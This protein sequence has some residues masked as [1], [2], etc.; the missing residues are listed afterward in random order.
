MKDSF[1]HLS[2]RFGAAQ[3]ICRRVHYPQGILLATVP[4]PVSPAKKVFVAAIAA[5]LQKQARKAPILTQQ[6]DDQ[7]PEQTVSIIGP[8][9]RIC[10]C[11]AA[12]LRYYCTA[13][14]LISYWRI[15]FQWSE[16]QVAL[17][18]LLGIQKA[19][20]HKPFEAQRRAQKLRCGWLPDPDQLP[21]RWA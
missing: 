8:C 2:E 13:S 7:R 5:L 6:D 4:R 1:K 9:G 14:D 11:L 17:V 12:E 19:L 20:A 3:S 21:A 15:R 10:D 16:S 18:D